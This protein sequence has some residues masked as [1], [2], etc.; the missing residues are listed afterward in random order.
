MYNFSLKM[1]VSTNIFRKSLLMMFCFI[2][3]GLL[4][5]SFGQNAGENLPKIDAKTQLAI[6]DSISVAMN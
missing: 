1:K 6:I 3:A 2:L 5:V 4:T